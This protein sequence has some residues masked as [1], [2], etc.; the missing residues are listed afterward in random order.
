MRPFSRRRFLR[1]AGVLLAGGALGVRTAPA[2][3]A[4]ASAGAALSRERTATYAALVATVAAGAGRS[5][6]PATATAAFSAWYERR[7]HA[8]PGIDAVLDAVARSGRTAFA[9]LNPRARARVLDRWAAATKGTAPVLAAKA[10]ALASPPFDPDGA[11]AAR[12]V[13]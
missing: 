1:L 4:G 10:R 12:A 6:Q 8:R 2:A 13:G 7:P 9:D 11:P 5:G 3:R